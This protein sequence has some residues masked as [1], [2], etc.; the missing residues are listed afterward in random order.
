[1]AEV[2]SFKT[3][4]E[5]CDESIVDSKNILRCKGVGHY[6]IYSHGTGLGVPEFRVFLVRNA[7]IN[8]GSFKDLIHSDVP[9]FVEN[10]NFNIRS[11]GAR[12]C[13]ILFNPNP[14]KEKVV[15]KRLKMDTNVYKGDAFKLGW[16]SNI[17]GRR[18][19][20]EIY[21]LKSIPCQETFL[22]LQNDSKRFFLESCDAVT[23]PTGIHRIFFVNQIEGKPIMGS[24]LNRS[25]IVNE[26]DKCYQFDHLGPDTMNKNQMPIKFPFNEANEL[27]VQLHTEFESEDHSNSNSDSYNSHWC[28]TPYGHEPMVIVENPFKG[29]PKNKRKKADKGLPMLFRPNNEK[30]YDHIQQEI[31]YVK[32]DG[33]FTKKLAKLKDTIPVHH[34]LT[35][36]ECEDTIRFSYVKKK[37]LSKL[38]KMG[39]VSCKKFCETLSKLSVIDFDYEDFNPSH[40]SMQIRAYKDG[41]YTMSYEYDSIP[42]PENNTAHKES[43]YNLPGCMLMRLTRDRFIQQSRWSQEVI[44]IVRDA[45]QA[46]Y[47]D[48]SSS[49]CVGVGSY[50]GKR[51]TFQ[52]GNNPVEG[53]GV[54]KLNQYFRITNQIHTEFM[55]I[56]NK[57]FNVIS[58]IANNIRYKLDPFMTK[59]YKQEFCE[60]FNRMK[61][62]TF[63]NDTYAAFACEIHIDEADQMAESSA[64]EIQ[65]NLETNYAKCPQDNILH[66]ERFD[67]ANKFFQ[68]Y[69]Y[70]R[71]SII[72]YQRLHQSPPTQPKHDKDRF[73]LQ[74]YFVMHGF[75]SVVKIVDGVSI[76]FYPYTFLHGSS[77]A[78]FCFNDDTVQVE[79][80][81]KVQNVAIS[82]T[83]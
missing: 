73:S 24:K 53:P 76:L 35:Y 55:V 42:D 65:Q 15:G 69:G 16:I 10:R 25:N 48:R 47:G 28:M 14:M 12:G 22:L 3:T 56:V 46:G 80:T 62:C 26:K 58:T 82:Y 18:K 31:F 40:I 11:Q 20:I 54:A 1:M 17:D 68:R 21:V 19:C 75:Q 45:N 57:L 33:N 74:Q 67:Y 50:F 63:G 39:R 43:L 23:I 81:L 71:S 44:S 78:L 6:F 60:N 59:L 4:K 79:N 64:N 72:Q 49:T 13:L 9:I 5:K 83:S 2:Y 51:A 27:A 66:K 38:I 29:I 32:D 41:E 34:P 30:V 61:T 77:V 36:D 52:A 70:G 7:R 8:D 37:D